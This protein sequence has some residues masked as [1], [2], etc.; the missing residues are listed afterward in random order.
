MLNGYFP[1]IS[2]FSLLPGRSLRLGVY[3]SIITPTP[4]NKPEI[5]FSMYTMLLILQQ[6]ESVSACYLFTGSRKKRSRMHACLFS[7]VAKARGGKQKKREINASS[8]STLLACIPWQFALSHSTCARNQT[9]SVEKSPKLTVLYC[10]RTQQS[11][12]LSPSILLQSNLVKH[13]L[14]QENTPW[15]LLSWWQI[16]FFPL[17]QSSPCHAEQTFIISQ[18]KITKRPS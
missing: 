12:P 17:K 4:R 5:K 7:G 10:I 6:K 2:C 14:Q 3:C 1:V 15:A 8:F 13:R 16:W 9:L 18:Y 11:H